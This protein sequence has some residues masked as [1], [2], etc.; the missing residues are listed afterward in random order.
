MLLRGL[1]SEAAVARKPRLRAS[2][3]RLRQ[4]YGG[5]DGGVGSWELTCRT[6]ERRRRDNDPV[7]ATPTA[8][9]SDNVGIPYLW[10]PPFCWGSLLCTLDGRGAR[11]T[12]EGATRLNV[13]AYVV[14]EGYVQSG[15]RNSGNLPS[16]RLS[17]W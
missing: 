15:T 1:Q 8:V 12:I 9:N 17:T 10:A 13:A 2:R 16:V 7:S 6:S 11:R 4:G 3:F 14:T 5:R